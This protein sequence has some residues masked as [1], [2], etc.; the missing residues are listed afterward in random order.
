MTQYV[1]DVLYTEEM[2]PALTFWYWPYRV[3]LL[4]KT[5]DAISFYKSEKLNEE[6]EVLVDSMKKWCQETLGNEHVVWE[7]YSG[8]SKCGFGHTFY[9]KDKAFA[10]LFKMAL[11]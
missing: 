8:F 3:T 4:R 2:E 6:L 7:Q 1:Y 11:P 10:T 9:F 5:Y